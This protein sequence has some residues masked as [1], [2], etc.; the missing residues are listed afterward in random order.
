MQYSKRRS[1][2]GS[3]PSRVPRSRATKAPAK[4][5]PT[6]TT[7]HSPRS[8]SSGARL[9]AADAEART[10]GDADADR[11]D[12]GGVGGDPFVAAAHLVGEEAGVLEGRDHDRLA[13]DGEGFLLELLGEGE[14]QALVADEDARRIGD[15][16]ERGVARGCRGRGPAATGSSG[17][18]FVGGSR[19]ARQISGA[20]EEPALAELGAHRDGPAALL[21]GLDALGEDHRARALRLRPHRVDHTRGSCSGIDALGEATVELDHVRGDERHQAERARVDADIVEGDPTAA[22]AKPADR[23]Q[24]LAGTRGER[25]LGQL[26]DTET[27][28]SS[29]SPMR[30]RTPSTSSPAGSTLRKRRSSRPSPASSAPVSA[31]PRQW[32]SNCRGHPRGRR[33]GRGH[34]ASPAASRPGRGERLEADRPPVGEVDDRLIDG[35][36]ATRVHEGRGRQGRS[37]VGRHQSFIG[38]RTPVLYPCTRGRG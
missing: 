33:R 20:A 25:P 29:S 35:A 14:E 9:G 23:R 28:P 16:L 24:Y 11:A 1:A 13:L 17:Q 3:G 4:W 38:P 37:G 8:R 6:T 10:G 31:T 32:R 12:Q 18:P 7:S 34:W 2:S 36:H 5:G 26:D 30:S 21:V 22:F 27:R 15:P 19:G